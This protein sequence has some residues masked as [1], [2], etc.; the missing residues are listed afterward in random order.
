MKIIDNFL[1]D[2][3][4]KT[5]SNITLGNS[6]SW[7]YNDGIDYPSDK[8]YQ[9]IHHF[10]KLSGPTDSFN[11]I[12]PFLQF[13][14]MKKVY[15]IK[16]NLIPKTIFHRKSHFHTDWTGLTI[17]PDTKT[18]IFYMNTTNGWTEFKGSRKV[19]TVANRLVVFDPNKL[20]RGVSCTDQKRRVVINFNYGV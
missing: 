17:P 16:A 18:A 12:E 2:Y 19:K 13:F 8:R 11:L 3:Y 10:Y 6:F 1:P 14:N 4:F 20:H 5:L 15:R 7:Y 9:F